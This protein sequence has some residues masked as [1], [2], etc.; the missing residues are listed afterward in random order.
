MGFRSMSCSFIGVS[1]RFEAFRAR[2]GGQSAC[3]EAREDDEELYGQGS[4]W[5]LLGPHVQEHGTEPLP[6]P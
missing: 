1:G 6:A 3:R 5:Q 2:F 4:Q